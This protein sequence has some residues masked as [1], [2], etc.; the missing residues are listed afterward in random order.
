[1]T[2]S[3]SGP[4]RYVTTDNQLRRDTRS[5]GWVPGNARVVSRVRT[6]HAG[7]GER[8]REVI[9]HHLNP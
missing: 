5:L 1:M 7:D 2:R 6:A 3:Q 9:L 4:S 8:A